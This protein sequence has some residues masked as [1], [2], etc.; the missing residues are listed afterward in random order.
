MLTLLEFAFS[1]WYIF[2]GI[3]I[4][5][6]IITNSIATIIKSFKADKIDTDNQVRIINRGDSPG[7]EEIRKMLEKIKIK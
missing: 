6:K 5:I 2:L 1:E 3:I 4:L 7:A